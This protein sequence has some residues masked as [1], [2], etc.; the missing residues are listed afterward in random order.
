M[1]VDL[2]LT[3]AAILIVDDQPMCVRLLESMLKRAGYIMIHT[4]TDPREVVHLYDEFQPDLV[5][6]DLH[7]PHLT[8]FEVIDQ[9]YDLTGESALPILAVTADL[10]PPARTRA[11]RSGA[12]TVLT[13]P[14]SQAEV[15]N[16]VSSVLRLGLD[17][18]GTP[19][20]NPSK[21]ERTPA[22]RLLADVPPRVAG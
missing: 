1:D 22:G 14:F 5:I 8:G 13:K 10:T 11:L 9:L 15:L 6:L 18:R 19:R 21:V 7:M 3:E 4:A 16:Q 17:R 2:H 20:R 12:T